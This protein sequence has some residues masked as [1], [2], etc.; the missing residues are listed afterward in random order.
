MPPRSCSNFLCVVRIC[1]IYFNFRACLVLEMAN[2]DN[3]I[4]FPISLSPSIPRVLD[5]YDGQV[6]ASRALWR[7]LPES[8]FD[9]VYEMGVRLGKG[10]Y[11]EVFEATL[12]CPREGQSMRYAVK[13]T[14]RVNDKP[15]VEMGIR[16]EVT[17]T[18]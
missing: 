4:V 7:L 17:V 9:G 13:R 8:G 18:R 5:G 12:R 10:G 1:I 16:N 11:A 14:R 15:T 3:S 6:M 2:S